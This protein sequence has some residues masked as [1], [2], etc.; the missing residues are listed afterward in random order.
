VVVRFKILLRMLVNRCVTRSRGGSRVWLTR[1]KELSKEPPG[2][3]GGPR[4]LSERRNRDNGALASKQQVSG[5]T[6]ASRV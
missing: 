1:V 4:R 3:W 5:Q 2:G 6:E